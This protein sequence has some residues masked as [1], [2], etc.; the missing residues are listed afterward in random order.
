VE[1]KIAK[2]GQEIRKKV[3]FWAGLGV[4]PPLFAAAQAPEPFGPALVLQFSKQDAK[5]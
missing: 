5:V 3:Q 2:L 1:V 4:T